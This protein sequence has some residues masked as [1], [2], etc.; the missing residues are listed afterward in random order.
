MTS[1]RRTSVAFAAV[2]ALLF[3]SL[4]AIAHQ[5]QA[6]A[7]ASPR[8]QIAKQ[9]AVAPESNAMV[10]VAAGAFDPLKDV[11]EPE[12]A[13]RAPAGTRYSFVQVHYP[14]TK[15]VRQAIEATG[16][17]ILGVVPDET[18]LVRADATA[19]ARVAAVDGVRWVGPYHPAYKVAPGLGSLP[20]PA[21][22]RVWG[23]DGVEARTLVPSL[24][25][26]RGVRIESARKGLAVVEAGK[27]AVSA[28]ARIE[29]VAWIEKLPA[30]ELHNR[31]ALWVTD[32]GERDKLAATAPGRLDGAGQ[33]AAV[34]DTGINYIP[35][36]NGR[37]QAAFSDCNAAGECKLADYVQTVAGN[38]DEMDTVTATGQQHRKMAGY[39]N[40]H[41]GDPKARS[42]EGSWHGTHVSG[43]VAGDYP[44]ADGTYGTR[45]R[46]ADG[47]AV[48]S[49]LI[50]QDIEA[51]GGLGG[52]PVDPYDLFE[53]VYDLDG[54]GQYDP[55]ADARTHNNSYGAIYPE[56]DD[57]GGTRTD[58][59][60]V[61]H[62]DMTIVFSA[63]NSGPDAASLAGGPQVSKN[64][65]TSC[66]SA[67]GRQPL[68][69]P[70]AVA[71][72][73]SHGPTL[74]G[75]LKPDVC[76][77]GQINVSPKGGTVEEDHYL[78]GTSM[79]GPMLVGLVTLVRQ[80]FWDGYGP[81]GIEGFARGDRSLA[82]RHNPSAALVKAVTINS[83][84]RMRGFYSGDDGTD[85]AQDGQWPS[86][87]QGWGKVEL[88]KS[89]YF[90]G[91][92]R[93]LFTVDRPSDAANGLETNGVSTKFI[94]V[95]PGQP[96]DVH[97]VWSDPSA[98]LTS[99]TP[100]LVNDLDLTVKAPDN[101]VYV[102]NE[103]TTQSPTLGPNGNPAA[104]VGESR[105]GG[106]PDRTNNVEGVRLAAP[107]P[108][109]YEITVR[110]ANV[111]E[112][113]QGFA[114][115]VSG[116]LA[117]DTPRIVL[118]APKYKP[119][120]KATAYLLGT[121][122]SGETVDGFTRRGPSVYVREIIASG[123]SV[124]AEA[125]GVRATAP[126]D[127]RSPAVSGVQVES[128]AADL[129]RVT[130]TTDEPSTG[131]V[132]I[133][134]PDG[135]QVFADVYN[136]ADF[137]GLNPVQIETKGNYLNR[138]V[139]T[140]THEVNATGVK[141]GVT[142]TYTV[143]SAD[144]A[145]NA[146]TGPT[147]TFT[148]TDGMY[149]PKAPDIAMLLSAE[150]TAGAPITD[151]P[152][153]GGQG[154]GTSTQLYA[155]YL[156]PVPSQVSPPVEQTP[157]GRVEALPAF[158]FRLPGSIDPK[159]ITGAA[160]ELFSAHDIHDTYTDSTA[161]SLDLLDSSAES[162]W[163]PGKSYQSVKSAAADV[164]LAADPTLRRGA[165]QRYAFHV[166]C[167]DI[168]DFRQN[169]A[170]DGT[171][172]KRAAFRLTGL[173]DAVE[174]LFSFEAG[175][176]RRSRGPQLRP[177]LVLFLDG[178][179]P[180]P[181]TTTAPPKVS[182]VLVD[183]TDNTS[184]VVSWRTDVPSDSTVYFR[185]AG[186]TDW[187]PVSAPVRVTQHFV[188]INGLKQNG[189][190]EFVVRSAG[191]SGAAT[192]DDNGGK[193]YALYNEPFAPPQIAG[194]HARPSPTQNATQ[195]IGWST[196]QE[197]DSVVRYGTSPQ[198]LTSEVRVAART[199]THTVN[200]PNL[201]PCTR[202][203][204]T[205][206]STNAAGK[207]ATSP[208]MA[209]DRSPASLATVQEWTFEANDGGW[210]NSPP[211]GSGNLGLIVANPSTNKTLWSRRPAET[212]SQGMR[213]TIKE[214]GTPGYTSNVDLR[215][216]SP[217]VAV[218]AGDNFVE[219]T[220]WFNL[221]GPE[222]VL[223]AWEQ[224]RVELSMDNGASWVALREGVAS[225]N[226]DF[227]LPSTMR[228]P[229]PASAAGKTILVA[230][231]L[232][233]DTNSEPPTGGWAVDDVAVLNGNC[234]TLA[235]VVAG[236]PMAP[237]SSADLPPGFLE[238]VGPVEP[239]D[240]SGAPIGALPRLSGA[241]SAASLAAGT[242]RCG[243]ITF[244]GGAAPGSAPSTPSVAAGGGPA[245]PRN[246][247]SGDQLP[248]TG[249]A[250]GPLLGL[251]ALAAMWL[252]VAARRRLSRTAP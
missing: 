239:V 212:G 54:D 90:A 113:P 179:D 33:T 148:S 22:L 141:A 202:Y 137:P 7:D 146:G 121:G 94:D 193:S 159:R 183:H 50:F 205:V 198:A 135:E 127:D 73:S 17:E 194:V 229:L 43:S 132:A 220:E 23:H 27:D 46:E 172:E 203:Y 72:F 1:S 84:Q 216:I 167:N 196:N 122:L 59:F 60:I 75:R 111:P 246:V 186:T 25:A 140:T 109:R 252:T 191:C 106:T 108:G 112:G 214:T 247:D 161:Y 34:A 211:E 238:P 171:T 31:N 145:G 134:G 195:I 71:I 182:N 149:A 65:I 74:D 174:S 233:T 225:N 88:D 129:A 9:H 175:F 248:A 102:G 163:G 116:R 52:L 150:T 15:P 242:C 82:R 96:L 78:Q 3:G 83:A 217:P 42:T 226:E 222:F 236:V 29:D 119:G 234:A 207:T 126:V 158:M 68:V 63:A 77:P 104:A 188:R 243:D 87:G 130:W 237:Q 173:T 14:A 120:A 19:L 213:T 97:L 98:L 85:R 37:A 47:I 76:T 79:S 241:P 26:V 219:F 67:N 81:T 64:V 51:D 114:L 66:A 20:A 12:P 204:F 155:G 176:N 8:E 232:L 103:F 223:G 147:G 105:A 215:L 80:Y 230:F 185:E 2:V 228:L 53:Q 190:Y 200:L 235:G 177:R 38:G 118:D 16:A 142:Y 56:F 189:G 131:E 184:A 240:G 55:L 136:V 209:F 18:Y 11:P 187:T 48:A 41:D 40:L 221:E 180:Q 249:A 164:E 99:G 201:S 181:C 44:E 169:L 89:L 110:G 4:A 45:N 123:P 162:G 197:S 49:R 36:D 250:G 91:D 32:T 128:V 208:V 139:M 157:I 57:G 107:A 30:Y 125:A 124:V 165:N 133:T 61:D 62:P 86:S 192:V 117:A 166:P 251:L 231:R 199:A 210:R 156:Q 35:D 170:E 245:P 93:N 143:R 69:S 28:I 168:E 154:W 115:A 152:V 24:R 21:R 151:L 6:K 160:V 39:F 100:V 144:E 224:P 227:P 10:R 95:A 58:D 101:T 13:L 138:K 5:R 70:D 178:V 206:S 244:L 218:P 153:V 92:D